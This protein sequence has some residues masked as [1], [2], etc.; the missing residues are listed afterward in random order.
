MDRNF[1]NHCKDVVQELHRN[2]KLLVTYLRDKQESPYGVV[3]AVKTNRGIDIGAS[4][5]NTKE[6]SFNKYIGTYIAVQRALKNTAFPADSDSL[7]RAAGI[8]ESRSRKY[9]KLQS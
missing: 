9:W 5:C 3:V 1:A 2:K 7:V 6:D 4:L 8:M